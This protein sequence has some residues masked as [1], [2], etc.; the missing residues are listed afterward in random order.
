[1]KVAFALENLRYTDPA[2]TVWMRAGDHQ[3]IAPI[4]IASLVKVGSEGV[5]VDVE[6]TG[7]GWKTEM[8]SESFEAIPPLRCAIQRPGS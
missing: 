1:M 5:S 2:G 8:R 7:Y 4:E 3:L 6:E